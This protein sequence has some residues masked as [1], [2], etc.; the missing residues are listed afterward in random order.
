ME[1][2]I[3]IVAV[4]VCVVVATIVIKGITELEEK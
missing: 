4:V 3:I 2:I 1:W